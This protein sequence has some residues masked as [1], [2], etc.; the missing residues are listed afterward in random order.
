MWTW[1]GLDRDSK[2]ILSWA[3]SPGRG[4][5]YAIE[6]MDDLRSRLANRVQLTTEGHR[7]YLEAVEGAFGG[8]VDYAQL[9]KI[10]GPTQEANQG[11]YSPAAC[12]GSTKTLVVGNPDHDLIST[13]FVERHNLTTRDVPTPVHP[14]NQRL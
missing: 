7:A 11:R 8:D 4:S 10:Y 5:E 2:L 12:L 6:L 14:P 9:V 3:V 1:T 13:S